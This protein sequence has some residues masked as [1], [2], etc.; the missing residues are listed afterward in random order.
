MPA[1]AAEEQWEEEPPLAEK[2]LAALVDLLFVPGFTVAEECRTED[3]A[4]AY[5]IWF[6][7]PLL[8][9]LPR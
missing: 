8:R 5:V 2:L 1:L 6:V 3:G 9:F 7:P 4:V